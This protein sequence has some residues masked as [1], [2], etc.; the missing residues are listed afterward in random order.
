MLTSRSSEKHYTDN[1]N[2]V[3]L[4]KVLRRPAV[5]SLAKIEYSHTGY[6]QIFV[7]PDKVL[8]PYL[9]HFFNTPLGKKFR[10]SLV[11]GSVTRQ[12]NSIY[13]FEG[14]TIY[15]PVIEQQ[16]EIVRINTALEELGSVAVRRGVALQ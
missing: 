13:A 3:Y 7:H 15:L 6:I 11:I 10:L 2:A 8:A 12:I 14:A 5:S 16:S 9:A 4:P 1:P